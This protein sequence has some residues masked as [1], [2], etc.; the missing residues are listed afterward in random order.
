[1]E[2]PCLLLEYAPG[3]S[4]T[5]LLQ[6]A[7]GEPAGMSEEQAKSVVRQV[8]TALE[9][10]NSRGIVYRDLHP[11]NIVVVENSG[12]QCYKL[13][14]FGS[15]HRMVK[16]LGRG[17]QFGVPYYRVPEQM[18]GAYHHYTLD[19]GKLGMLLLELRTGERVGGTC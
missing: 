10:C 5:A 14:D 11:G 1:V 3:G 13:I 4:V 15:A 17:V 16:G 19:T 12:Q 18:E 8:T 6:T 2:R 9:D 7:A